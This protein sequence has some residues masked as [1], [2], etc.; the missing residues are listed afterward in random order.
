MKKVLSLVLIFFIMGGIAM[1]GCP[2]QGSDI[3][4]TLANGSLFVT[5]SSI[6]EIEIPFNTLPPGNAQK[7]ADAVKQ[8]LQNY[9]DVRQAL[10]TLPIDDPDRFTN[11]NLGF[12]F[13]SDANGIPQTPDTNNT[14]LTGRNCVINIT[15]IGTGANTTIG[16]S[17]SSP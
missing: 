17:F 16:A 7:K 9:F 11:P 5:I 8:I 3:S 4:G 6:G 12:L 1:A 13:W 14:H 10:T 15:V 2:I